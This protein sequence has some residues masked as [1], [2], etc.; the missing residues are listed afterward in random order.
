MLRLS[1]VSLLSQRLV[2]LMAVFTAALLLCVCNAANSSV[3]ASATF[4]AP[5]VKNPPPIE[6]SLASPVWQ[7]GILATDFTNVLTKSPATQ[8]TTARVLFDVNSVYVVIQCDQPDQKITTDPRSQAF[9][10]ADFAGIGIDPSGDGQNVYYFGATPL[11]FQYFLNSRSATYFPKWTAKSQAGEGT[12]T[13]I[14]VIPYDAL[15]LRQATVQKWRFNIVRHVAQSDDDLTWAY[16][17]LM[18]IP[19]GQTA[20]ASVGLGGGG[21]PEAQAQQNYLNAQQSGNVLGLEIWP[22]TA[23]AQYWPTVTGYIPGQLLPKYDLTGA[24]LF[25]GGL[26]RKLFL[27][28]ANGGSFLPIAPPYASYYGDYH[29]VPAAEIAVQNNEFPLIP[30]SAQTN[31]YLTR[32]FFNVGGNAFN[33][34]YGIP[35][36]TTA[37]PDVVIAVWNLAA[38]TQSYKIDGVSGRETFDITNAV[39]QGFNDTLLGA[40]YDAPGQTFSWWFNGALTHHA[41]GYLGSDTRQG[42]SQTGEVGIGG[43]DPH[44]GL[45]GAVSYALESGNFPS[46]TPSPN[47]IINPALASKTKI[48]VGVDK[49]FYSVKAF[50]SF[51]GP[52][53]SPADGSTYLA[54]VHGFGA[55]ATA[56]GSGGKDS[57]L[58]QYYFRGYGIR[59]TDPSG[60]VTYADDE[61]SAAFV[62]KQNLN[63][64]IGQLLSTRAAYGLGSQYFPQLV[65]YPVNYAG[66][67]FGKLGSSGV[68]LGY[69]TGSPTFFNVS[70]I[71]GPNVLFTYLPTFL[72]SYINGYQVQWTGFGQT[73][74]AGFKIQGAYGVNHGFYPGAAQTLYPGGQT[75]GQTMR[76][77][78]IQRSIDAYQAV[79]LGYQSVV[80]SPFGG[81]TPA[82]LF[83]FTYVKNL[84]RNAGQFS[85]SYGAQPLAPYFSFPR[86]VSNWN[87]PSYVVTGCQPGISVCQ[88]NRFL[89]QYQRNVSL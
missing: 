69:K 55:E 35:T 60:T 56:S 31:A 47:V 12:W 1:W 11:G 57:W 8:K 82:T 7:Q 45:T 34:G 22:T 10:L 83:A 89:I 59:E 25:S 79:L 88:L 9:G 26:Q 51:I 73:S 4:V 41:A 50:Y 61:F 42:F 15:V 44:T 77:A 52:Q 67:G 75:E 85:V 40:R 70:Y 14:L 72:G 43:R 36:S 30:N 38:M 23:D 28:Q 3:T 24:G 87:F 48:L 76:Y 58:K 49:P 19:N 39:G 64:A 66:R 6:P 86:A 78:S 65:G 62:T 37:G 16:D 17:P 63:F 32:P 80:G 84:K 27:Q 81:S 2:S 74:L 21:S 13:T 20:T 71:Y 68:M 54:G 5:F 29:F 33:Q 53:F 18:R 46:A